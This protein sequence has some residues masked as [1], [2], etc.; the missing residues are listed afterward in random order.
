MAA[1]GIL[2]Y[3]LTALLLSLL[4]L[5]IFLVPSSA[6]PIPPAGNQWQ[7]FQNLSGCLPGDHNPLL[8]NLKSY[9]QRFGYL[10]SNISNF[11]D[12]FD[13]GLTS[14]LLSYQSNL[15][16]NSTG[17]LDQ[18]TLSL[19]TQPRCGVADVI[20]NST[21]A[22]ATTRG[23]HLY[24]YFPG[25][26]SWSPEKRV[27]TYAL[28]DTSAVSID[29]P[30]LRPV[31]SRAFARWSAATTLNFTEVPSN[32]DGEIDITIGF[33]SGDHGDGQPFDGKLG[34]LAHAFSPTDGRFHLD[35]A[36]DWVAVGDVASAGS[37]D[38]VDLESVAVHEIGHLLGLAHSS[39]SEAVMY[40][41]LRPKTRK[42]ELVRDDV[43]GIQQLYGGNPSYRDAAPTGTSSRETG[44]AGSAAPLPEEKTAPLVVAAALG[45]ALW[46]I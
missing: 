36:E 3:P 10:P 27:L 11:S 24:S 37:D 38:A 42:V 41:A 22:A 46:L 25:R 26:P 4:L 35:A 43:D 17:F 2:F 20:H 19:L 1:A 31:F 44:G 5:S 39:V 13:D 8:P 7:I 33:Y 9:F 30:T 29:V 21:S 18:S 14:A 32:S 34:T 16:L 23:R 12:L 15:G 28:T 6:F 40:P 45:L